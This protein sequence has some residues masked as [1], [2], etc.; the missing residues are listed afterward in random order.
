MK[1]DY[2]RP[3]NVKRVPITDKTYRT[4]S[5]GKRVP[6]FT[7]MVRQLNKTLNNA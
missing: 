4:L 7:K 2:M 1:V 6:T 3:S 5:N